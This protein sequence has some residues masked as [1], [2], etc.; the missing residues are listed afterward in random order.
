LTKTF[1]IGEIKFSIVLDVPLVNK[2][3][4]MIQRNNDVFDIICRLFDHTKYR[5]RIEIAIPKIRVG[6]FRV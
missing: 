3:G 2:R 1:Q 4:Y 5:Y 6:Q